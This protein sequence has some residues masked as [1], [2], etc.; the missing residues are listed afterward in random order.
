LAT[1]AEMEM[2][3]MAAMAGLRPGQSI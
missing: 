1:A 2:A 3:A